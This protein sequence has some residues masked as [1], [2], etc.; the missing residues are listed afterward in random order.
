MSFLNF[1]W[2]LDHLLKMKKK[3]CSPKSILNANTP[4]EQFYIDLPRGYSVIVLG[5]SYLQEKFEELR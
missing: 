2:S 3:C 4:N 1:L 5:A